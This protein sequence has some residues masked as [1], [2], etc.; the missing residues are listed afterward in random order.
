MNTNSTDADYQV[1]PLNAFNDNYIWLLRKGDHAA[2]VDPGD[3]APVLAYLE[4]QQLNL[5]AILATH[6]HGDHIGGIED[7]LTQY[8]VPVFGPAGEP[9]DMLTRPL[10]DGERIELSELGANFEVIAVPGHTRAHIAYYGRNHLNCGSLFCGDTLFACGCGR[11][12]EGTPQQMRH[13]LARLAA[14]PGTTRV[15]C[16]HEYTQANIRFAI[17]V[18]PENADLRSRAAEVAE[19][20]AGNRPTVPST[21]GMELAVNPF[22]RWK[23]PAVIAAAQRCSGKPLTQPDEVFAAIREWKNRF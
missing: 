6:H 18:E 17:A 10:V 4:R 16:A 20:R 1:V 5:C 3:A 22:L 12:F 15:Y 14:L 13:S 21:I 9:I 7:L 2:V 19:L 8:E 23:A 11:V